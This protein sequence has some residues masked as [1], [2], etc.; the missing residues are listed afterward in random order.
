MS[1]TVIGR[2]EKIDPSSVSGDT[3][4]LSLNDV[5]LKPPAGGEGD[6]LFIPVDLAEDYKGKRNVKVYFDLELYPF[7]QKIKEVITADE[8]PKGVLRMRR[9]SPESGSEAVIR[10]DLYALAAIA[11]E[12]ETI[13]V[14]STN[15]EAV[16]LHTILT[17][18]FAGGKMAHL[19]YTFGAAEERI[20]LE[21]SGIKTIAEFDSEEMAP[22]KPGV[23]SR[24]PLLYGVGDILEKSHSA[25]ESF[26]EQLEIYKTLLR[27]GGDL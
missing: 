9:T 24:L 5:S 13:D 17:I 23:H 3:M 10:G 14:R 2:L 26:Y 7:F 16:P 27:G 1:K 6:H 4:L 19:E 8:N 12:Q 25:D 11:G 15:Q 22:V 18:R 21:W 20:E